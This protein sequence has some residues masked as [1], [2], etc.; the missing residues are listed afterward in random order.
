MSRV[1]KTETTHT[2]M[3]TSQATVHIL[4]LSLTLYRT[5]PN[6]SLYALSISLYMSMVGTASSRLF[7]LHYKCFTSVNNEKNLPSD[8]AL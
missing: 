5:H 8:A 7:I 3:A 2:G 6:F 4:L 1:C